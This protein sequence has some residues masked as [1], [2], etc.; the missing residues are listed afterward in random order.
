[1]RIREALDNALAFLEEL[2]LATGDDGVVL[3]L[4]LAIAR[5]AQ[6]SRPARAVLELEL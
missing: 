2:G 1:V 3:D 4:R 5:L 6:D